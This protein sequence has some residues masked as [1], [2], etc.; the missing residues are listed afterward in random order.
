MNKTECSCGDLNCAEPGR[1][2]RIDNWMQQATTDNEQIRE[3]FDKWPESHIGIATGKASG[4]VVLKVETDH[5]DVSRPFMDLQEEYGWLSSTVEGVAFNRAKLFFYNYPNCRVKNNA[6]VAKGVTLLADGSYTPVF[7]SKGRDAAGIW[8]YYGWERYPDKSPVADMPDWLLEMVRAEDVTPI[9]SETNLLL[10]AESTSVE[11]L[12]AAPLLL[13]ETTHEEDITELRIA[14]VLHY[15]HGDRFRYVRDRGIWLWWDGR[16]WAEDLNTL[17]LRAAIKNTVRDIPVAVRNHKWAREIE[18]RCA[19]MESSNKFTGVA[20]QAEIVFDKLNTEDLDQKPKLLNLLNGTI[21]LTTGRLIESHPEDHLTQ[22]ANVQ[23]MPE[24]EAPLWRAF[25]RLIFDNNDE[26]IRYVQQAVG[27]SLTG[28]TSER[29][30]FITYGLGRNGKTT[31]LETVAAVLGDYAWALDTEALLKHSTTQH[32]TDIAMLRGKRFVYVQELPDSR[33]LDASRVKAI[34]GGDTISARR[35]RQDAAKLKPV[36]KLWI[37]SNSKPMIDDVGRAM[38]DRVKII[39][40]DVTINKNTEERREELIHRFVSDEGP[41]ILR[42]AVEG[43]LEYQNMRPWKEPTVIASAIS[44]YRNE[45]DLLGQ[46]FTDCCAVS[47]PVNKN[48]YTASAMLYKSYQQWCTETGVKPDV[49]IKFGKELSKRGFETGSKRIPTVDK[50]G[51]LTNKP[52][53]VR[54]GIEL[55]VEVDVSNL[56]DSVPHDATVTL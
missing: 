45:M 15:W 3:W 49:Q 23:Y 36:C 51:R 32:S 38:W 10:D 54:Y 19:R 43:Y 37:A 48:V 9:A 33:P 4:I 7:P 14:E 52:T 50:N 39:P 18:T 28:D 30:F 46:F 13:T 21:D 24:A 20:K 1:H 25:L 16:R 34:S 40:F 17:E 44:Q 27:Y 11:V 8:R 2:P 55:I 47:D 56:E 6:S 41:G 29:A 22:I 53:T 35:M 5:N 42:W 12:R 26:L 31:F